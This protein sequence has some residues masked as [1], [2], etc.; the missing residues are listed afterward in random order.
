VTIRP[1]VAEG[2]P[3]PRLVQVSDGADLLVVGSR[4]RGEFTGMLLGSASEYCVHHAFA[5]SRLF[6]DQS[7]VTMPSPTMQAWV[8]GT[9]P[10]R[11]TRNHSAGSI[12]GA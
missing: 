11:S 7:R 3:A 6:D 2:H 1:I 4:G 9:G 5:L 12:D 8:V 10:G